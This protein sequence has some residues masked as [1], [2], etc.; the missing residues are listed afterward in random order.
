MEAVNTHT[1]NTHTTHKGHSTIDT[2]SNTHMARKTESRF[3]KPKHNIHPY[4][5]TQ[6]VGRG[7]KVEE[8]R[9]DLQNQHNIH[10]YRST[11]TVGRGDKGEV[12]TCACGTHK[13][14]KPGTRETRNYLTQRTYPNIQESNITRG[15]KTTLEAVEHTHA[16]KHTKEQQKETHKPTHQNNTT[17]EQNKHHTKLTPRETESNTQSNTQK[18]FNKS[19]RGEQK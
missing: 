14:Q 3:T 18:H 4:R 6:T 9:E 19:K 2:Q 5:S 12:D 15:V 13:E 7:D 1:K 8:D 16:K 10:P 17:H 11:Q